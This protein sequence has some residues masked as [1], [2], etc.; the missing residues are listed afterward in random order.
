MIDAQ[1]AT[2][3][4]EHHALP[5]AWL[6]MFE[7]RRDFAVW[8]VPPFKQTLMDTMPFID[9]LFGNET[10]ARAFAAS[11]KWTETDIPTIA[12]KISQFPKQ[13]GARPRTVVITQG[14]DAT[15]VANNAQVK[16]LR[17]SH[18]TAYLSDVA[19]PDQSCTQPAGGDE[20]PMF[21]STHLA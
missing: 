15:V 19:R 17:I 3:A 11:E 13:S 9:F 12:L 14:K 21:F 10:E 1:G 20:A 5:L 7:P 6:D 16:H 18:W 8:Q 4:L 2:P